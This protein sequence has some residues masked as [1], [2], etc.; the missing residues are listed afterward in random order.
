MKGFIEPSS[1]QEMQRR[2]SEL[3]ERMTYLHGRC[4]SVKRILPI[5]WI[6]LFAVYLAVVGWLYFIHHA[7][8]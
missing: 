1:M 4:I 8:L 6:S 3:E 5:M 2:I 7:F